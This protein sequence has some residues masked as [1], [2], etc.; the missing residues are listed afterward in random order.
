MGAM[1]ASITSELLF[2]LP[3]ILL[4]LL[5]LYTTTVAKCHGTHQWRRQKKKRP[6]LPPGARGWPLVGE[7][8]GYLRAHPAT[9][10]GRFMERHVAR[11]V[12]AAAVSTSVQTTCMMHARCSKQRAPIM[13]GAT[14]MESEL[15]LRPRACLLAC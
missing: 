5:A 14:S 4:A 15:A 1:M 8:F 13:H 2:F 11:C 12:A 10:V 7:T 9:S 3:F 6:N